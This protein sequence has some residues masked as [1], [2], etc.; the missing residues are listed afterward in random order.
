MAAS[1]LMFKPNPSKVE[2]AKTNTPPKTNTYTYTYKHLPIANTLLP[3]IVSHDVG[4]SG[5]T[6][7]W[8]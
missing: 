6:E 2:G 3:S 8:F 4:V 5:P 1:P 7:R